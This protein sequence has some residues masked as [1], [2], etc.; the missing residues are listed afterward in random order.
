[1][2]INRRPDQIISQP[3]PGQSEAS[4]RVDRPHPQAPTDAA[5]S[6]TLEWI[7]GRY[8]V[9]RLDAAAPIPPWALEI[10]KRADQRAGSSSAP[11]IGVRA[12]GGGGENAPAR[13]VSITRTDK[14]LSIVCDESLVPAKV[15]AQRGFA[16]LRIAGKLDFSLVGILAKLTGTLASVGVPVFVISTFDTDYVLV[17]AADII[18]SRKALSAVAERQS[19]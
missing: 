5:S 16:A 14:E 18:K 8:A 6:L 10:L 15:K 3:K 7:A 19:P 13:L 12:S 4:A 2:Y 17:R 1:L 9:C 11:T